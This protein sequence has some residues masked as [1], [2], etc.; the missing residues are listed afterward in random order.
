ME[1]CPKLNKKDWDRQEFVWDNKPFYSVRYASIIGI[2]LN[3]NSIRTKAIEFLK[4]RGNLPG[5]PIILSNQGLFFGELMVELNS[6]DQ[7]LNTKQ[8]SGKFYSMFFEGKHDPVW[9]GIIRHVCQA[10]GNKV[11]FV[12]PYYATCSK[13]EAEGGAPQTVLIAR[14]S[15]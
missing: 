10:K 1:C 4:E 8:V 12:L 15:K 5:K 6:D 2:P 13:C 14:L 7:E 3:H 11:D 9:Y